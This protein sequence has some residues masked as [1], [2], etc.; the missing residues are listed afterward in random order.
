M[1]EVMAI[2]SIILGLAVAWPCLVVWFA[3]AFP[4]PSSRA[5]ARLL[6]TPFGC[7]AAG[8]A[9]A[10]VFGWLSIALLN[11]PAGPIKL[12][13]WAVLSP[14]LLSATVGAA[15]LIQ[16]IAERLTAASGPVSPLGALLRAAVLTEFASL[17]PVIGWFLFGP[18]A[19]LASLGG[20]VMALLSRGARRVPDPAVAYAPEVRT[21]P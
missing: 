13:G 19:T 15:G 3:L 8:A 4:G 1:G 21:S 6:E 16:L 7:I 11:H 2:V 20:G 14:L 17:F 18:I 5:R 10:L 12:V 9:L